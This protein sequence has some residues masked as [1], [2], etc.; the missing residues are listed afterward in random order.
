MI[1]SRR[2]SWASNW[3]G[4]T[5]IGS[6]ATVQPGACSPSSRVSGSA[7]TVMAYSDMLTVNRLLL[8]AGV[9]LALVAQQRLGGLHRLGHH[10]PDPLGQ[11]GQLEAAAHPDQQLV[12][13]V[14]AQPG[15][16]AAHRRLAHRHPLA[17]V[18]EVALL[19]EGVQGQ[20]Q[21]GVDLAQPLVHRVPSLL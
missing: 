5:S 16:R 17:G 10:R 8:L 21:V 3:S 11:G 7:S 6:S 15:Q 14:L 18:G 4:R 19:E 9:E 2:I 12:V 13:E 20:Q 1:R